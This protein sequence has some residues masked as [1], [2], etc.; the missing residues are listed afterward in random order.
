M[1]IPAWTSIKSEM[2]HIVGWSAEKDGALLT[3]SAWG[4]VF[5]ARGLTVIT[6]TVSPEITDPDEREQVAKGI[7]ADLLRR[8]R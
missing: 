5:V 1:T 8:L 7:A 4:A 2:G 3:V 6:A